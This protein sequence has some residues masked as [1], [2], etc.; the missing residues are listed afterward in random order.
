MTGY[1]VPELDRLCEEAEKQCSHPGSQLS[2]EQYHKLSALHSLA[3]RFTPI[4]TAR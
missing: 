1:V 2:F 3:E 4:F